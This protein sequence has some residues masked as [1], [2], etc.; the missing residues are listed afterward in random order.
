MVI[1]NGFQGGNLL[2]G[3][4]GDRRNTHTQCKSVKEVGKESGPGKRKK[5]RKRKNQ[6]KE[7]IITPGSVIDYA[8]AS[9]EWGPELKGFQIDYDLGLKWKIP[10]Q[11]IV[12]ELDFQL[13]MCLEEEDGKG[14]LADSQSEQKRVV[15]FLG[16]CP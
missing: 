14:E 4:R 8:A 12:V 5:A 3:G 7:G 2:S 6:K 16:G 1:L 15:A 10:H 13:P 9:T 11:P